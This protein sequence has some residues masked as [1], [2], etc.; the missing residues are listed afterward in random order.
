MAG[1]QAGP[2]ELPVTFKG[3]PLQNAWAHAP[4]HKSPHLGPPLRSLH[5]RRIGPAS[6]L[7]ANPN[8]RLAP[9]GPL[10]RGLGPPR[11]RLGTLEHQCRTYP[12]APPPPGLL[13]APPVIQVGRMGWALRVPG[14][15]RR[16]PRQN[17]WAHAP[18]RQRPHLGPPLRSPHSQ[19]TGPAGLQ[20]TNPNPRSAPEGPLPRG[21]GQ[22]RQGLGTTEHQRLTLPAAL[23]P[24]G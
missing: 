19:Q 14:D 12:A 24:S 8:P 11:W 3:H 13:G 18:A 4:A 10:P 20:G 5:S 23:P 9:K 21:L 7:G 22:P 1:E 2:S 16:T 15:I 17:A 6:H